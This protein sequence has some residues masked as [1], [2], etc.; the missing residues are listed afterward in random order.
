MFDQLDTT[1]FMILGLGLTSGA[2]FGGIAM[3][4]V[5]GRDGFGTIGN[6]IIL[7]AGAIIGLEL[8][9]HYHWPIQREAGLAVAAVTTAFL[10]LAV[11]AVCKNV[12]IRL[13]F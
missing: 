1:T 7:L 9:A 4:G 8:G 6:M 11:L 12:L 10:G 13:G 3:D 2:F 5:M